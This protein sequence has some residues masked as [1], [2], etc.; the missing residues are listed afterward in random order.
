MFS[1]QWNEVR[2]KGIG[3]S[4]AAAAMGLSPWKTPLR[5]YRE[6]RGEEPEEIL[7]QEFIYWGNRLEALIAQEYKLRTN[8][9]VERR[10]GFRKSRRWPWMLCNVDRFIVPFA[11]PAKIILEIKTVNPFAFNAKDWGEDGTKF[12]PVEYYCQAQHNMTVTGAVQCDMPILIGG[13]MFRCYSIPRDEDFIRRLVIGEAN[14][15]RWIQ[16]G[17]EPEPVN[18]DD[19]LMMFPAHVPGKMAEASATCAKA[20]ARWMHHD[21]IKSLHSKICDKAKFEMQRFM[22]DA[23]ILTFNGV[24]IATWRA[25]A[26]KGR[27]FLPKRLEAG[28]IEPAEAAAS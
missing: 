26:K 6:K 27:T 17:I 22:K 15:W 14:F 7:D 25:G 23:E 18:F 5:L 28:E 9:T 19:L 8:R 11:L 20:H 4:D 12:V 2:K 1:P 16:T 21:K 3:G 24:T 10:G 13:N